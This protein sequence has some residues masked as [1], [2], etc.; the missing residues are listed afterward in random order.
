MTSQVPQIAVDNDV[1]LKVAAYGLR[2]AL[3]P[4]G[5]RE[6]GILAAARFVVASHIA[7]GPG[8]DKAR[9][10]EEL[11]ALLSDASVLEP[12]EA[13]IE[14]AAEIELAAQRAR[15]PLDPGESQLS[16]IVLVRTMA[17]LQTGDKRAI[18]GLER[19][20]DDFTRLAPLCGRV[21]SLEQVVRGA[22]DDGPGFQLIGDAICAEPDLDKTLS[23]CFGCYG[24]RTTSAETFDRL[25]AY[26]DELRSKAPR[27]LG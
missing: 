7:R 22:L 27:V 3:W 1:V 5:G 17:D 16:A 15:V 24:S 21:H 10:A 12:T 11:E 6:I 13:E 14:F 18:S 4:R 9:A 20:L 26:I 8:R 19:L 25:R 2:A 23:I